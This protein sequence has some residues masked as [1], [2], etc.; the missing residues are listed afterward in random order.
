[1]GGGRLLRHCCGADHR[2]EGGAQGGVDRLQEE[3][4]VLVG[5]G[6]QAVEERG[7]GQRGTG[8]LRS[9]RRS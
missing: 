6:T 1:M 7:G 4:P 5:L 8:V 9:T 2:V 3:L